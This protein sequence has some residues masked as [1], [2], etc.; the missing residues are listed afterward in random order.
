M[1]PACG[2]E[3]MPVPIT[4]NSDTL[5][6]KI[7]RDF[8]GGLLRAER[9]NVE[10]RP[11]VTREVWTLG[12]SFPAPTIRLRKGETFFTAFQNDLDEPTNVHWHGLTTPADMDGHPRDEV[13]PETA[14]TYTFPIL[15]RAGTY[16][17]HPHPHGTTAKQVYLGMAGF[18]IVEDDEEQALELPRGELDVP[19]LI[20]D[21][22]F[23]T[24]TLT[25]EP[26]GSD[27]A[28]G[29]LGETI[30]VN[31]VPNAHL[32]VS[33]SLYRFR[34]LNG[35]NARTLKLKMSDART[36]HVI[37]TDGGLLDAP[38]E[39]DELWL[40]PAERVEL[41]VDFSRDPL[42]ISVAL[43]SESFMVG[44]PGGQTSSAAMSSATHSTCTRVMPVRLAT[45]PARW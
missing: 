32:E 14:R 28:D 13:A 19:L 15:D 30:F 34:V 16:W 44:D 26:M 45:T 23:A 31:G 27:I 1:L 38:I 36:M 29:Y 8:T 22:R 40:S 10:L 12:G 35:S 6:L 21:K 37:A 17:Y 11:G 5:P 3:E 20:Q 42:D 2:H 43:L 41:L 7:P 24:E 33:T 4:A 25:Y 9:T 18:F 39:A